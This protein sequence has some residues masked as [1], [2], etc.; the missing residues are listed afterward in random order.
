MTKFLAILSMLLS[1]TANAA[2]STTIRADVTEG[3]R[4]DQNLLKNGNFEKGILNWTATSLTAA[5]ETTA[6]NVGR[7]DKSASVDASATGQYFTSSAVAIP[8]GLYARNGLASCL[9]KTAAT[10]YL[11]QAYDGTNVLGEVTLAASS[12]FTRQSVNFI[13]PSSGNIQL[14]IA[15]QS[16]A[17]IMYLDD[18]YVGDASN[19][20]QVSQATLVASG[21]WAATTNCHWDRNSSTIGS[22]GTTAACP[23]AT[24]E[25]NNGPGVVSTSASGKPEFTVT[26]LAPGAYTVIYSI[27]VDG[28]TNSTNVSFAVSDGTTTNSAK[29]MWEATAGN[30]MATTVQGSFY[31][32]TAQSSKTFSVYS[33]A[34]GGSAR[35]WNN[36][37]TGLTRFEIYR[38]PSSSEQAIRIENAA[39]SWSGYHDNDCDFTSTNTGTLTDVTG[40][41]TCTFTELLNRNFGTVTSYKVSSN[42]APGIVFTPV[43]A[44][45]FY[46]CAHFVIN[47]TSSAGSLVSLYDGTRQIGSS[48]IEAYSAN[49]GNPHMVCGIVDATS[50]SAISLR[51]QSSVSAGTLHVNGAGTPN[52]GHT[53]DWTIMAIDQ[54]LP[55]PYLVGGVSSSSSGQEVVNRASVGRCTSAP[56]IGNVTSQTGSWLSAIAR[57]STGNYALTFSGFSAAPS[58]V[59]SIRASVNNGWCQFSGAN[60][61]TSA[62]V[63]VF[64]NGG[65]FDDGFDIICMGPK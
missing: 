41:S 56:C 13:F 30:Q 38:F 1:V 24:L 40:D 62:N 39:Q 2:T 51:L 7:G 9:V 54:A 59:C 27:T 19:L 23:A 29:N 22:P 35:I 52:Y 28:D 12:T 17:A 63:A 5:S 11:L 47:N 6:A 46:A 44:G 31:Y 21:Y 58:C 55:A 33:A 45:R 15:S 61:S 48:K 36:T 65:Q 37:A 50:T 42:N 10:D 20:V 18:C 64:N 26:N 16:N 25:A 57:P 8:A 60:T 32:T 49:Q 43:R 3:F 4:S 53:V 34:S 14:R